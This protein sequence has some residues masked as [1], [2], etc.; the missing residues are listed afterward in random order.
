M[1]ILDQTPTSGRTT[2]VFAPSIADYLEHFQDRN[3]AWKFRNAPTYQQT[4]VTPNIT[5]NIVAQDEQG[6]S[7]VG[8]QILAPQQY[9]DPF[10]Y[11]QGEGDG[12]SPTDSEMPEGNPLTAPTDLRNLGMVSMI[13][14]ASVAGAGYGSYYGANA[15]DKMGFNSTGINPGISGPEAFKNAMSLG[16]LGTNLTDQYNNFLSEASS[17]P[18]DNNLGDYI[19][20]NYSQPNPGLYV[21]AP[22]T[23]NVGVPVS[24]KDQQHKDM[25]KNAEADMKHNNDWYSQLLSES[26]SDGGGGFGGYS[27]GE[28]DNAGNDTGDRGAY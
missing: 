23:S 18:D 9:R 5:P 20:P 2:G 26:F 15:A 14:G 4:G 12:Y 11:D 25:V 1:G 24:W 3:N 13:P 21:N 8:D 6:M 7:I 17:F 28:S 10:R 27:G 22:E 16:F 19:S